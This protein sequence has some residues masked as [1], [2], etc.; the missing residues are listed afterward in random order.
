MGVHGL[1]GVLEA[2]SPHQPLQEGGV[3]FRARLVGEDVLDVVAAVVEMVSDEE[4]A[5][6]G[7]RRLLAAHEGDDGLQAFS[8]VQVDA[9]DEGAGHGHG[10]VV[11]PFLKRVERQ[12][13][14]PPAEHCAAK[15]VVDVDVAQCPVKVVAVEVLARVTA[16]V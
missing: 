1:L 8:L 3:G 9:L 12:Q 7:L 10:P 13:F 16:T 2:A 4:G 11:R 6:A 15:D 5:V 14:R